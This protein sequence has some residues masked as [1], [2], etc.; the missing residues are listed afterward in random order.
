LGIENFFGMGV[1]PGAIAV[2]DVE[3]EEFGGQ[4][5]GGDV[6][7]TEEVDALFQ[8]GADVE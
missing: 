3:E 6:G 8:G 4:G 5:V 7:F 2:R 1:E